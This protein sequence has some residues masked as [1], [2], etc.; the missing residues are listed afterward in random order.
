MVEGHQQRIVDAQVS[1]MSLRRD[2]IDEESASF[3]LDNSG[4]KFTPSAQIRFRNRLI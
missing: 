1:L 4:K 2:R 3:Y